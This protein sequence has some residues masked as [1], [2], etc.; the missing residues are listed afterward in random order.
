[1]EAL[2]LSR[3]PGRPLLE[4][5]REYASLLRLDRDAAADSWRFL[6][7]G[8][9]CGALTGTVSELVARLARMQTLGSDAEAARQRLQAAPVAAGGVDVGARLVR[10]GGAVVRVRA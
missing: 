8:L 7:D 4:Q 9:R 2:V 1:L 5:A 10:I 3:D 6:Q